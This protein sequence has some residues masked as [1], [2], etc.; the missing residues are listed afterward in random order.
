MA[1][2]LTQANGCSN[3]TCYLSIVDM[4]IFG[5]PVCSRGFFPDLNTEKLSGCLC[6]RSFKGFLYCANERKLSKTYCN[7]IVFQTD[8][9]IAIWFILNWKKY[10]IYFSDWFCPFALKWYAFCGEGERVIVSSK[11]IYSIWW[12]LI[13]DLLQRYI[14]V[15]RETNE[16]LRCT[17]LSH[18]II[19]HYCSNKKK[20]SILPIAQ[21]VWRPYANWNPIMKIPLNMAI[22]W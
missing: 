13:A 20:T 3:Y 12:N 15:C 2:T 14:C 1:L 5:F 8:L 16:T 9:M 19:M 10:V 17:L 22:V 6:A 21:K 7:K 18:S 11:P 4:I